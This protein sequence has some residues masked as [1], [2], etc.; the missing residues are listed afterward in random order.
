MKLPR[1]P[2]WVKNLLIVGL[3]LSG[4]YLF[5]L[6]PL[7][8][9]SPMRN[10]TLP[11]L[12]QKIQREEAPSILT[13]AA[14]P[15]RLAITNSAG[16]YGVEYDSEA[17]D[18]AFGLVSAL[19]G[20]A[21]GTAEMAT[22]ISEER[23]QA[24]LLAPGIYFDFAGDIP[25][26]ALAGWIPGDRANPLL[27][28]NTRRVVISLP[29]P[30]HSAVQLFYQ[31]TAT[32]LFH[33]CTTRLSSSSYLI[34][35]VDSFTPNGALF[36]FEDPA[37]QACAPYTLIT[38]TPQ[39]GEYAAAPVLAAET[40]DTLSQ[41]LSAL[42]FSG[43]SVN[44]FDGSDGTVYLAGQDTLQ[45][46][47]TGVIHYTGSERYPVSAAGVL[48]T[49]ADYLEVARQLTSAALEPLCGS[50]QLALSSVR[51]E[52]GQTTITYVY[53][54]EGADLWLGNEG[55]AAQ[56]LFREGVLTNFTMT[57]RSYSPT[58]NDF[59]VI[60]PLQASAM[61]GALANDPKELQLIY[62]DPGTDSC[63]ITAGWTAG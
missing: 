27:T 47:R 54:L 42:S 43:P 10:W 44:S 29:D 48:P 16:R 59:L 19:L 9:N 49:T 53:R 6:S 21:L 60:P 51:A 36:A 39:L 17:M 2:E 13:T 7:Y 32:G 56:F 15:A 23:W 34:P 62:R 50:A 37:Y 61:L 31:D 18:E 22:P 8:L 40:E 12:E 1:L 14:Q 63:T 11:A 24:A 45:I 4:L 20:E 46:T 57:P 41:I 5:S 52:N 33:S 3:S 26:S 38:Q 25:F 30:S 35:V 55:Y 58:G 28:A